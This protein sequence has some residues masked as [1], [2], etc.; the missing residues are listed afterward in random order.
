[1]L[2]APGCSHSVSAQ[3]SGR[4][5]GDRWGH[6]G[7]EA[8]VWPVVAAAQTRRWRLPWGRGYS[9]WPGEH[10]ALGI[11]PFCW[12]LTSGS[13]PFPAAPHQPFHFQLDLLLSHGNGMQIGLGLP[14]SRLRPASRSPSL[15]VISSQIGWPVVLGVRGSP[16]PPAMEPPS[17]QADHP[18]CSHMEKSIRAR[19]S[20]GL[21][22]RTDPCFSGL[23]I[24]PCPPATVSSPWH[25]QCAHP[26]DP[27]CSPRLQLGWAPQPW[28]GEEGASWRDGHH[29]PAKSRRQGPLGYQMLPSAPGLHSHLPGLRR[30]EGP[31]GREFSC[32]AG[33]GRRRHRQSRQHASGGFG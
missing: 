4:Q 8:F 22:S 17:A 31:G 18:H 7:H 20:L 26:G 23:P 29:S 11:R 28:L 12:G 15:G 6:A 5:G 14:G 13:G 1:M 3:G 19:V 16:C 9:P 33:R 30:G 21:S 32:G 25:G 10:W 2:P 27:R 24:F